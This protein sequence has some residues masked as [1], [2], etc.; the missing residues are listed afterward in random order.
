MLPLNYLIGN[1]SERKIVL[2]A[3]FC[4]VKKKK[5]LKSEHLG[6][7]DSINTRHRTCALY[8]E[9]LAVLFPMYVTQ[10]LLYL[11]PF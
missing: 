5:K 4:N 2:T 7:S 10:L 1:Y 11:N 8:T 9:Q 6:C 3:N